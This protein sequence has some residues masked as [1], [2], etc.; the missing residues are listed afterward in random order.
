MQCGHNIKHEMTLILMPLKLF[1]VSSFSPFLDASFYSE[2]FCKG[3]GILSITNCY[4]ILL[5]SPLLL[6]LIYMGEKINTYRKF[7]GDT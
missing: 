3:L 6:H 7:R 4:N 5:M 2:Q 1:Y